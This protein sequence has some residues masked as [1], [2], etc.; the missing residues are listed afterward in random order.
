MNR[1]DHE[2]NLRNIG[3]SVPVRSVRASRGNP[4]NH[5]GDYYS[6]L[7]TPITSPQPGSMRSEKAFEEGWIGT[8]VT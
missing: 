7:A 6:V 1:A 8:N 5:D 3:V 4:R 2:M